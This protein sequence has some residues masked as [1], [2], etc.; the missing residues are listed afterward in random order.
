MFSLWEL[1]NGFL[2]TY[3]QTL[4]TWNKILQMMEIKTQKS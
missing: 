1:I 3:K 4:E 2:Q